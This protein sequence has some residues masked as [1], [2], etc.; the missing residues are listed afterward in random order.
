MSLIWPYRLLRA[1]VPQLQWETTSSDPDFLWVVS[2]DK[3]TEFTEKYYL[4][5]FLSL[6]LEAVLCLC[7]KQYNT[8]RKMT[9]AI[10]TTIIMR[11]VFWFINCSSAE[12]TNNL[13][14]LGCLTPLSTIFQLY[15]S[16]QFY[17]WRKLEYF[18]KTTD[19]SLTKF[20]T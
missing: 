4:L 3:S 15:C 17:W 14:G 11:I 9:T 10:P 1:M 16:S 6:A 12:T 5:W 7:W 2:H 18:E 8:I 13:I 19:L 20:I